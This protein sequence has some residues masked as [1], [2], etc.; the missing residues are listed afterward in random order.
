LLGMSL[1]LTTVA[2]NLRTPANRVAFKMTILTLD[3]GRHF[4]E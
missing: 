4:V 2:S 1:L 3:E